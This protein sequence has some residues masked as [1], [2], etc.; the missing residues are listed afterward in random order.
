MIE[1]KQLEAFERVAREGNFTR[2]AEEMRL[3]QPAISTRIATLEKTLGG[4]LFERG[5]RQLRLTQLGKLFLPYAERMLTVLLDGVQAVHGFTEG[6]VGHVA[7]AA[8][9]ALAMNMLSEAMRQFRQTFPAI[10]FTIR[11]RKP[12]DIIGMLYDGTASLGLTSAPLWDKGVQIQAHF[13]EP[14]RAVVA[15][16]HA[17]AQQQTAQQGSLSIADIY[18]HTIYRVTINA[19]VTSMIESIVE[20]ARQGS[21]GAV[22]FLPA[23][24][25]MRLLQQGL[26]MAFLPQSF[27]QDDV[28]AGDLVFLNISDL[29]QLYHEPLLVSLAGRTLDKPNA[30]FV[31]M[32]KAQ[33]QEI[34]VD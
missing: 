30:A 20:N 6:K 1:I 4:H 19:R 2:A 14:V 28:K 34:L 27:V 8:L 15:A 29:P 16:T 22:I 21:G 11:F 24:M 13:Q 12:R 9:D 18:N 17:L 10:D 5:G 3:S 31:E 33:W 32:V 26:G 7:I 23:I 25:A